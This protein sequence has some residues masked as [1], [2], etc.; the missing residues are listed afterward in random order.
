VK[1]SAAKADE[2][3]TPRVMRVLESIV[4]MVVTVLDV[5]ELND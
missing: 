4:I 3:K 5:R 1:V 2:A